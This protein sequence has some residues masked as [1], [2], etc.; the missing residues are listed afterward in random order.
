MSCCRTD[1][2]RGRA[3]QVEKLEADRAEIHLRRGAYKRAIS[4]NPPVLTGSPEPSPPL[5]A[6]SSIRQEKTAS[7]RQ[8][9]VLAALPIFRHDPRAGAQ[10]KSG[11]QPLLTDDYSTR[12]NR[13][14]S[15]GGLPI[16]LRKLGS[17]R[18]LRL[19]ERR[20]RPRVIARS[21]S[22][23]CSLAGIACGF[24]SPNLEARRMARPRPALSH[25]RPRRA[26]PI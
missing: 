26:V 21:P 16:V 14:P 11:P 1:G 7:N 25:H 5:R 18:I 8:S 3:F 4:S 19:G 17:P 9:C 23:S 12:R 15:P 6:R 10:M 20:M 13:R 2:H 24:S 22:P